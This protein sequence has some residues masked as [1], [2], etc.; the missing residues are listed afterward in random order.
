MAALL[1]KHSFVPT[2]K[3]AGVSFRS[4]FVK[5]ERSL[6]FDISR[7]LFASQEVNIPYL[8]L[9]KLP[10]RKIAPQPQF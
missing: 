9:G 3:K 8:V 4:K 10:P 5:R 2:F 6:L 1:T 7:Y